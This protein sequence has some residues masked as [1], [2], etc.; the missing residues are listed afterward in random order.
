MAMQSTLKMFKS[1]AEKKKAG[2]FGT[3]PT[4]DPQQSP[5]VIHPITIEGA[6]PAIQPA[7]APVL[8]G[9]DSLLNR[10]FQKTFGKPLPRFGQRY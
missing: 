10:H 3:M 4:V 9:T 1:E 5:P 7:T 2:G 6:K 8:R